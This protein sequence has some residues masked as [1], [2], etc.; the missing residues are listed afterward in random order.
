MKKLIVLCSACGVGKSTI[1]E[2]LLKNNNLK[3][4]ICTEADKLGINCWDYVNNDNERNFYE[5]CLIKV[6]K[7]SGNKNILFAACMNPLDYFS[8]VK[9]PKEVNQTYFIALT[10]SNEEIKKRLLARPEERMCGSEE[11]IQSQIEYNNWFK[12]NLGKFQ[13]HLDNSCKSVKETVQEIVSFINKL[14]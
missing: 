8:K 2:E 12:N 9:T 7:I 11:F 6:V 4:Y 1:I 3:N 13:F 10:C 5:D 14:D